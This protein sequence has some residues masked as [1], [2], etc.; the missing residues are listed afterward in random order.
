LEPNFGQAG[1]EVLIHGGPFDPDQVR[2]LLGGVDLAILEV[3]ADQIRVR[4]PVDGFS[5]NIVVLVGGV[6]SNGLAFE[7]VDNGGWFPVQGVESLERA[8]HR[9]VLR[10]ASN[11][12][13]IYGGVAGN[14]ALTSDLRALS[15]DELSWRD[16]A[17]PNP[18]PLFRAFHAVSYLPGQ[19]R[20][21]V[22]GGSNLVDAVFGD[23]WSFDFGAGTWTQ[24]LA[25][26]EQIGLRQGASLDYAAHDGMVYLYGGLTQFGQP[27][28]VELMRYNPQDQSW[29]ALE[30][31]GA[32]PVARGAHASVV[33][34]QDLFVFGG[35]QDPGVQNLLADLWALDLASLTWRQLAAGGG[36]AARSDSVLVY[37]SVG[38][39]LIIFGGNL[40][41]VVSNDTWAFDLETESW[42]QL[43]IPGPAVRSLAIGVFLQENNQLLLHGGMN[44]QNVVL[45]DLWVGGLS[46][47]EPQL[48]QGQACP[49]GLLAW[50]RFEGNGLDSALNHNLEA[51]NV[52][53]EAGPVGQAAVMAGGQYFEGPEQGDLALRDFT[54]TTW[55]KPQNA[56]DAVQSILGRSARGAGQQDWAFYR[57]N[58]EFGFLFNWP[59][60]AY[61]LMT[62]VAPIQFDQWQHI[63]AV[64][65]STAGVVRFYHNGVHIETVNLGAAIFQNAESLINI[66]SD[67]GGP[68]DYLG[69]MDELMVWGETLSGAQIAQLVEGALPQPGCSGLGNALVPLLSAN[70]SAAPN[71][72]ISEST[73]HW[74]ADLHGWK[75]FNQDWSHWNQGFCLDERSG[76]LQIDFGANPRILRSYR[77]RGRDDVPGS[78]P[79]AWTLEGSNNEVDWV[80]VSDVPNPGAWAQGEYKAYTVQAPA[81]YRYYR[82]NL[83]GNDDNYVIT[84]IQE[85]ELEG[86]G[87]C[88]EDSYC[89]IPEGGT[90]G[91]CAQGCL[92][93]SDCQ[94]VSGEPAGLPTANVECPVDANGDPQCS[95]HVAPL[96]PYYP[97]VG[98][99]SCLSGSSGTVQY[100]FAGPFQY[101]P[102]G[103]GYLAY[104][105][106]SENVAF[107]DINGVTVDNDGLTITGAGRP[108]IAKT[109]VSKNSG[110]W[111][112]EMTN[113]TGTE[114]YT[115]GLGYNDLEDQIVRQAVWMY[116]WSNDRG[117]YVPYGASS[118]NIQYHVLPNV[119][120]AKDSVLQFALDA[121]NNQ[122]RIG[123]NGHWSNFWDDGNT[124][125]NINSWTDPGNNNNVVPEEDLVGYFC[126]PATHTCETECCLDEQCG[127]GMVC[128]HAQGTGGH[129]RPGCRND[130][131]CGLSG[132][133]DF[134]SKRCAAVE[135]CGG[136]C[137]VTCLEALED[138]QV[139][140]GFYLLR[141]TT[142]HAPVAVYCDMQNGGWTGLS[143]SLLR[144]VFNAEVQVLEATTAGYDASD[145]I[146]TGPDG[147]GGHHYHWT[148][149]FPVDYSQFRFLDYQAYGMHT[150]ATDVGAHIMNS[151]ND[152]NSWGDIGFGSPDEA[153]PITT[154][155]QNI[156]SQACG[157]CSFD[158]NDNEAV[159]DLPNPSARFRL[160]WYESGGDDEGWTPWWSGYILLR[161]AEALRCQNNDDC[162]AP[163]Y[164]VE[165]LNRCSLPSPCSGDDNCE[166]D[167]YCGPDS[168]CI[169]GCRSGTCPEGQ[170]CDL[171][172]HSCRDQLDSGALSVAIQAS[173][174]S[175]Y[176][177]LDE[178]DGDV[179]HDHS[180]NGR[181]GTYHN[182]MAQG[183]PGLLGA[184]PLFGETGYVTTG[185]NLSDLFGDAVD[186]TVVAVARMPDEYT[187]AESRA[188]LIRHQIWS[189]W[190]WYQ[191]ISV[192][193]VG[194]V[195][196]L[197]FWNHYNGGDLN[198]VHVPVQ[199]GVWV[200]MAWVMRGGRIFGY[201]NGQE[202]SVGSSGN[203]ASQGEFN[204]GRRHQ[205][206]TYPPTYPGLIQHVA[207]YP[208]GLSAVE[209][210]AQAEAA[211][212]LGDPQCA[213]DADCPADNFCSS[214]FCALGCRIGSCG[215]DQ[216]CNVEQRSCVN[217]DVCN[218]D[219]DCD[220]GAFCSADGICQIAEDCG[221][222]CGQTCAEVLATG[223]SQGDG[224][225]RL[226]IDGPGNQAPLP[227]FCDMST[228][229]GG[230]TGVSLCLAR[231][232]LGAELVA[233]HATAEAF[234]EHCRP[235]TGPDGGGS[236]RYHYTFE[237]PAEF[238]EFFLRDFQS[239]CLAA[240]GT[241]DV[242]WGGWFMT[243]WVDNSGNGD[244]VFGSADEDGPTVSLSAASNSTSCQ[245]CYFEH[246]YAADPISLDA[247]TR[248]F[249]IGWGESGGQ[250]EG[251]APWW[252]GMVMIREGL[253]NCAADEECGSNSFCNLEGFCS[254][255]CRPGSCAVNEI[256]DPNS[257][258]CVNPAAC[259]SDDD[260][261]AGSFCDDQGLCLFAKDCNGPCGQTC[262]DVLAQGQSEGNG[263][264]R[265]DTDGPGGQDPVLALCDMTT[266]GGGW[267]VVARAFDVAYDN[268]PP[269]IGNGDLTWEDWVGHSWASGASH[270]LSLRTFD[271][272]TDGG[273]EVMQVNHD[274]NGQVLRQLRL[275]DFDYN[276]V[277]NQSSQSGC[278]NDVGTA[279]SSRYSWTN[280][281]PVFDGYSQPDGS[282]T[283]CNTLFGPMIFNYH[284]W[285]GCA[286]DSGL[287]SWLGA[288]L[289]R[290]QLLGDYTEVAYVNSI[291]VRGQLSSCATD[292]DCP[293]GRFCLS[294]DLENPGIDDHTVLML[295]GDGNGAAFVDSSARAHAV[296]A[297]GNAT[298][299]A[300]V[301]KWG[302]AISLD[303]NGDRLSIPDSEDWN[304]G[305][306]DFTFD[307]WMNYAA[308]PAND[309]DYILSQ[310]P[311]DT[312]MWVLYFDNRNATGNPGLRFGA[313]S[314]NFGIGLTQGNMDGWSAGVWYHI[315]VVRSGNDWSLYRDGVLLDSVVEPGAF[316]NAT[317]NVQVSGRSMMGGNDFPGYIDEL[318]ISRGIARWTEAFVPP[319]RPYSADPSV[320]AYGCRIG[321]CPDGQICDVGT[322]QCLV[323]EAEC[324]DGSCPRS[325][326][327]WYSFDIG[328][329]L[330]SSRRS[331]HGENQ[332]GDF[333]DGQRGG[334]ISLSDGAFVQVPY[335]TDFAVTNALSLNT[336][337]RPEALAGT[338]TI[339]ATSR[340]GDPQWTQQDWGLYLEESGELLF[341]SGHPDETQEVRSFSL[342]IPA[343]EWSHI[344]VVV[345]QGSVRFYLNGARLNE[346]PFSGPIPTNA[347]GW[348]GLGG[349]QDPARPW[350][351][352]LDELMVW[353]ETLDDAEVLALFQGEA[354]S[355]SEPATCG[356]GLWNQGESQIDCGGPCLPCLVDVA[357][358][359][360]MNQG[361]LRVWDLDFDAAGNAYFM[362]LDGSEYIQ[363]YTPDGTLTTINLG[364]N[365]D[366]GYVAVKPDGSFI[367]ARYGNDGTRNPGYALYTQDGVESQILTSSSHAL[368]EPHNDFRM[369][370]PTG[371]EYGP[372]GFWWIGNHGEDGNV[373]RMNDIGQV[374]LMGQLPAP[375]YSITR[376]QPDLVYVAAGNSVYRFNTAGGEPE[377]FATFPAHVFS[378]AANEH[379]GDIYVETLDSLVSCLSAT[380]LF[381]TF[382]ENRAERA[383]LEV[384]PDGNLYR[385]RG[386]TF[387]NATLET[388]P[389][390][391]MGCG[392]E[393]VVDADCPDAGW[394]NARQC[395]LGCRV[396]LL[397]SCAEGE[398]CHPQTHECV[399]P[400]PVTCATVRME[401]PNAASGLYTLD[402]DGP[403]P[404]AETQSYCDMDLAGGG[405]ALAL[406]L[407]TSDGHVMWWANPLWENADLHGSIDSPYVGDL[408]TAAW[409]EYRGATEVMV[410][411][412]EQGHVV[413]WKVF[414]KADTLSLLESVQEG[415]NTLIGSR[416]LSSH[417]AEIWD[418]ERL[419]R[420]S[421]QL[422]A[423]HCN[424]SCV[425]AAGGDPDGV[426]I[427]SNEA[428]PANDDT[429]GLGNWSDMGYCCD[430]DEHAGHACNGNTFRTTSE[431][432]GGW[433]PDHNGGS[434]MFGVDSFKPPTCSRGAGDCEAAEWSQTNGVNYDY[435]ILL[436]M[437]R[438]CVNDNNCAADSY[439]MPPVGENEGLCL[440]GCRLNPDSCP[441][442]HTCDAE[443]HICEMDE[444]PVAEPADIEARLH[445]MWD[446]DFDDMGN[447]YLVTLISG[448]DW[449][450]QLAPDGSVTQLGNVDNSN[451]GMVAVKPDGSSIMARDDSRNRLVFWNAEGQRTDMPQSIGIDLPEAHNNFRMTSP[452]GLDYGPDG[453]WWL[454]NHAESGDVCN[455]TDV[456]V[457]NCVALLPDPVYSISMS[458]PNNI[459]VAAG[460]KI[461]RLST[462]GGEPVVIADLGVH[463]FSI[464]AERFTGELF[465]ETI[466]GKIWRIGGVT[467]EVSAFLQNLNERGFL[468][469]GPDL[470]LYRLRGQVD[471]VAHLEVYPIGNLESMQACNQ[472]ADCPDERYC[473][474][475]HCVGCQHF[476]LPDGDGDGA[477]DVC[478]NCP[479]LANEGQND[480]DQDGVGNACDNDKD[481][482]GVDDDL[483]NC[484][485]IPNEDQS[486][487]DENG[488]GDPCDM[489]ACGPVMEK[490]GWSASE[491]S[492]WLQPWGNACDGA[493]WNMIN[494]IDGPGRGSWSRCT[495]PTGRISGRNFYAPAY[496]AP[497]DGQWFE[498]D[499]GAP[500]TLNWLTISQGPHN[501]YMSGMVRPNKYSAW[502]DQVT[503]EFDGLRTEQFNFPPTQRSSLSLPGIVAQVIHVS[504]D[505]YHGSQPNPSAIIY[506]LDIVE[507]PEC[508]LAWTPPD[509]DGDGVTDIADDFPDDPEESLDS[510][511]DGIGNNADTD[512]DGD[513]IPDYQDELPLV[514]QDTTDFDND[515]LA[516][517][518]D[519]DDDNDGVNDLDDAFP[520]DPNRSQDSD[521]DSIDDSVDICPN[522]FDPLQG[523]LDQDGIGDACDDDADNDGFAAD[524]DCDDLDPNVNPDHVE[525]GC[526]WKDD[527]CNPATLDVPAN[528]VMPTPEAPAASCLDA[529]NNGGVCNGY[530]WIDPTGGDVAD[531]YQVYC[532]QQTDGGGWMAVMNVVSG[533]NIANSSRGALPVEKVL[534]GTDINESYI[535]PLEDSLALAQVSEEIRFSCKRENADSYIDVKTREEIWFSRPYSLGAGCSQGY[536]WAPDASAL[537]PIGA[538]NYNNLTSGGG[539]GCCCRGSNPLIAYPI[540]SNHGA[541]FVDDL[542]YTGGT[543]YGSC[544][545]GGAEY[546]RVYYREAA[547]V[548]PPEGQ[549]ADSCE[550]AIEI[551]SSGVFQ[552]DTRLLSNTIGSTVACTGYAWTGP[553]VFYKVQL[554]AG[555]R[556]QVT[557]SQ[558]GGWDS[559]IYLFSDCLDP[560]GSCIGGCDSP[561][562]IDKTAPADGTYYFTLD[563]Y[564]LQAGLYELQV[565]LELVGEGDSCADIIAANPGAP[566][567]VYL[568]DPDGP[569]GNDPFEAYCDM[570]TDGGGWTLVQVGLAN[571][572]ADL[573]T[574]L[575]VNTLSSPSPEVSAKLS[576]ATM[577]ALHSSGNREIRYG[578]ADYGYLYLRNLDPA[579]IRDG[580][581]STGYGVPIEG[582]TSSSS[583]GGETY[584]ESRFNWPSNGVPQACLNNCNN[585][586]ECSCGLHLGTWRGA[587]SDGVYQNNGALP[588]NENIYYEIWMAPSQ[589]GPQGSGINC[590]AI[591]A[592]NPDSPDGIYWIDPDGDGGAEP[593]EAYCDMTTD[594]GG[595]T[596]V[597][598]SLPT[599]LSGIRVNMDVVLGGQGNPQLNDQM[600][601]IGVD[602]WNASAPTGEAM[603]RCTGGLAGNHQ[604]Q[605]PFTLNEAD[606]HKLNWNV[607]CFGSYNSGWGLSSS[608]IDREAWRGDCVDDPGDVYPWESHG[609]G[610]HYS[611][612][613]GTFWDGG[614]VPEGPGMPLCFGIN[615]DCWH[616]PNR[617]QVDQ[618]EFF[619]R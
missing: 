355:S 449:V 478:D 282:K 277:T 389:L 522:D 266:D 607:G 169:P 571:G 280:F 45:G 618:V 222:V 212:L 497:W 209:I 4:I 365:N 228:D 143:P 359:E 534:K 31:Q 395:E 103:D 331:H 255:G 85:I 500:Q 242:S 374:A 140:D 596:R 345:N 235:K 494:G 172:D 248:R 538:H 26:Q 578:H 437:S 57:S 8:G 470:Q 165:G 332:G 49:E 354:P 11:E 125:G 240:S 291:M 162:V 294:G 580:Y 33:I 529:L 533:S 396:D 217:P 168:Q 418:G 338:Q 270:Y 492:W 455:M 111:Y 44:A 286:S 19:D 193:D 27:P 383:F 67:A 446:I 37:D 160:S 90:D 484:P 369:E 257:H 403:G 296:S 531:A 575:A 163:R 220:V 237:F 92:D 43:D 477:G 392:M 460:T 253:I 375:V 560:A 89:A 122:Y 183:Q 495:G 572:S 154:L 202:F 206:Q 420:S 603:M 98:S 39:R 171:N 247:A 476:S 566:D 493:A 322:G 424:G 409:S 145:R 16:I 316:P 152:S 479:D 95:I 107:T 599:P 459:Y 75:A 417:L 56:G 546:M 230:W 506:E 234:D 295:H 191:G 61:W 582:N 120:R 473:N 351:G 264:Y 244:V 118:G 239:Y 51:H 362:S 426:R 388:Y 540:S 428:S 52:S 135:D 363:K 398:I 50:W 543:T 617:C 554:S 306:D 215:V 131:E 368:A 430:A 539:I 323:N 310:Y 526:N 348:I 301:S 606:N 576:R 34:G 344:A 404:L 88:G 325:L 187:Q 475:T 62:S 156:Q 586:G 583:Y 350:T 588:L 285:S 333:I 488:V 63:A 94:D 452:T 195:N 204:I 20:M 330:D 113:I 371:A 309:F 278:I 487:S 450:E 231:N 335:H 593:F 327:A 447:T 15:L 214:G 258:A 524:A 419:V 313:Q 587:P 491:A 509:R 112:W 612:H 188:T 205:D 324:V 300:D 177:P 53:Y 427:G 510:D 381:T 551:N 507:N 199:P 343:G 457:V 223:R 288:E 69:S 585:N 317:G 387:S 116:A 221:G 196:G 376:V 416:V 180:G 537:E 591:L 46:P 91:V 530:Y 592:E 81:A 284:N 573:N 405:W 47:Q 54:L 173:N 542:Y 289:A 2:V 262:A 232:I 611:C 64:V 79:N 508:D 42:T 361:L 605:A 527:D 555:Q 68:N 504:I 391:A 271:A 444:V 229:G 454:G 423:N 210:Q 22:L 108:S 114:C 319:A 66:G 250:S 158:I 150:G 119:V 550:G 17:D 464:A 525:V 378:I 467:G 474:G 227:I 436:R 519:P 269:A 60:A 304:I 123:V 552:G 192:G 100:N 532:D 463:I 142:D 429:S 84:C 265:L 453:L 564:R 307:L 512:D 412:H 129:C 481:N 70:D 175:A 267:T 589:G 518:V 260:C 569:G 567:G 410:L 72:L 393:C 384:G 590:A 406:N 182:I 104:D 9:G 556:I 513:G 130:D 302:S 610:W 394:C 308:V 136:D 548:P 30:T 13:I 305:G 138:G 557:D 55:I 41:G 462:E 485:D 146:V 251:W 609:W 536:N 545:D 469:V 10:T 276:S 80:V 547:P 263:Y 347:E 189:T 170:L 117:I 377:L 299:S 328:Q 336:W 568:I 461:Y 520:F 83:A 602:Q 432:Q 106:G 465:A 203:M 501:S 213:G 385:L 496:R 498:I 197:H 386:K 516:D 346:L 353:N 379:T 252:S 121:D 272:L 184:A 78:S 99:W 458:L 6:L 407:D 515:G 201:L 35:R 373:H 241:C 514:A 357:D 238:Q 349:A 358:P 482:D 608:D 521:G 581:G 445:S 434:G 77:M 472:Q 619:V 574:D 422:F 233:V 87:E 421:T 5:G 413:G 366:T 219:V 615:Q 399:E 411:I 433:C 166:I 179:A 614:G 159:F 225:Y 442:N 415:D 18:Q 207:T 96:S 137:G 601:W 499:F 155:A 334:A 198:Q 48:C 318:R 102:P 408:K 161:E 425:I 468:E 157:C 73:F 400:L 342:N 36:P 218:N 281:P 128:S 558:S 256:C 435:A 144:N 490:D 178:L 598:N 283:N 32:P 326:V 311:N 287:F 25:A 40:G 451:L 174:P 58:S 402:P 367:L 148:L 261:E 65:D 236:H 440:P 274:S 600:G 86:D 321:E 341:L 245:D 517:S 211:G 101:A 29:M 21:L 259:Q 340:P 109:N 127:D 471:A 132:V 254:I 147:G 190:A 559:G 208:S 226:D 97:V 544:A 456:G 502:I 577:L 352:A 579:W 339:I 24:E 320:C 448:A 293:N 511:G 390:L 483:D 616:D 563:G 505:S 290:P 167:Q 370:T 401:N 438:S 176:W 303:G 382:Q 337:I 604:F 503:I 549:G 584:A 194:G 249:R 93:N 329:T 372:D 356:D 124:H 439:C 292:D 364:H 134:R 151:W 76:W 181:H 380:G 71:V 23:V 397:G 59:D 246:A 562:T 216:I 279:C 149:R 28:E 466:D 133:C 3:T 595:W 200:H 297:H 298:Q 105:N 7:F 1:T 597:V 441:V 570:T 224:Y 314:P 185:I 535:F 489:G 486:D 565:T 74:N 164:C 594:G 553:E 82:F 12:V 110:K 561:C 431:A 414:Q 315:A 443:S 613:C 480:Q 541:W 14:M 360:V 115:T 126:H 139:E 312:T 243:S 268:P 273:S 38:H 153:G 186:G 528:V 275:Q 523:D 141:L